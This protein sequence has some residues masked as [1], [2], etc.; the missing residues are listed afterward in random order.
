MGKVYKISHKLRWFRKRVQ[1]LNTLIWDISVLLTWSRTS[2]LRVLT[3][4]DL[5]KSCFH[6]SLTSQVNRRLEL[7]LHGSPSP[8]V[9]LVNRCRIAAHPL[10]NFLLTPPPPTLL[11]YSISPLH[12]GI[13]NISSGRKWV[14]FGPPM[15]ARERETAHT[16]SR[17]RKFAVIVAAIIILFTRWR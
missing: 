10:Q 8:V 1:L 16:L 12:L 11:L 7:D 17:N 2:L 3:S 15:R 5:A 4:G 9:S 6:V 14:Y 13:V